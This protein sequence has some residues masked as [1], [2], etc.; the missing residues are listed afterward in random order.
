MN[1]V[2]IFLVAALLAL[3]ACNTPS[4]G[5]GN[6]MA[7]S[8]GTGGWLAHIG[9]GGPELV[10]DITATD[11]GRVCAAGSFWATV[12][13]GDAGRARTL[14]TDGTQDIFVACYEDTGQ[15]TSV[16]QFGTH[17]GEE[18]RSIVALPG[19]DVVITGYFTRTF[20]T[21]EPYEL[22]ADNSADIFLARLSPGGEV[23]W[24][25]Q[26]GGNSADSG[27]AL[28][29]TRDGHLLLAGSF[30]GNMLFPAGDRVSKLNSAGSADAMVMKLTDDG[31]VIWARRLGG[32][33]YD[34]ATAVAEADDGR[35]VMAGYFE[36]RAQLETLEPPVDSSGFNDV[37]VASLTAD[38]T[39][40]WLREMGGERQDTLN[41]MAIDSAGRIH[42]TGTFQGEMTV[43]SATL[44][45][46]GSSDVYITRI[47]PDGA[48]Q[49]A[50]SFG[51]KHTDQ[52]YDLARDPQS[53]LLFYVG[54][55]QGDTDFAPGPEVQQRKTAREGDA[56]AFLLQLDEDAQ[57]HDV[58]TAGG[59]GVEMGFAVTPLHNV[60]GVALAG[61]FNKGFDARLTGLETLD[62]RGKSDVFVLR[63]A[64]Q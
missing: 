18:V 47:A 23:R 13:F 62:A 8:G 44:A 33:G 21:G 38:G 55:F 57:F 42:V 51:S 17:R 10:Y 34:Q 49:H 52:V 60:K 12:T 3:T 11:D 45:S 25:K 48:V 14:S 9:G 63:T 39:P 27:T 7:Y 28:A 26:F 31:D 32:E 64:L 30:S 29:T 46:V 35:I 16:T 41:G 54:Q 40:V 36:G 5:G 58:W 2:K 56:N 4:G 19:G 20:G 59:I 1:T 61:V 43:G 22:T 24:A 37:F 53:G 6:G 15:L 50:H